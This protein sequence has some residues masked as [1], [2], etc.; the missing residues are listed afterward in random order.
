MSR[1]LL[2]LSRGPFW[3]RL[4]RAIGQGVNT[5]AK[6][7]CW[8]GLY[9]FQVLIVLSDQDVF[10]SECLDD[11]DATKDLFQKGVGMTVLLDNSGVDLF[12]RARNEGHDWRL[13]QTV[14]LAKGT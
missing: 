9:P 3:Y 6:S 1:I 11:T 7:S 13:Y 8:K 10:S 2:R 4:S 14:L 5:I 12:A